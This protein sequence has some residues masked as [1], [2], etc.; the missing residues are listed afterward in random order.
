MSTQALL[1]VHADVPNEA[2]RASFDQWYD[3]HLPEALRVFGALRAW[4][5]W[6]RT[7]P[8]KHTAFYEFSSLEAANVAIQSSGNE[9][10]A[11]WGGRATRT[12]DIVEV[13]Q[14][15]PN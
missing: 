11:K 6:S 13:A 9:F 15:L 4:R 3:R 10:D 14:R 5:T 12:R 7:D 2:D 8:S 1:I